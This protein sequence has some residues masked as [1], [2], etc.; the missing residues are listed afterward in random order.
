VLTDCFTF[1]WPTT[2]DDIAFDDVTIRYAPHLE[3]SLRGITLRIPAGSTVAVTGRTGSGKSTL[4]LAL[5]GTVLADPSGAGSGIWIGNMDVAS[6]N[7]H[8]LRRRISFVAQD[9]VL[10]PGSLRENL[11]PIGE[12]T[13]EECAGVLERVMRGAGE[14]SIDSRVDGGGKNLSQGQRQLVGLGRAV[15]RRSPIV[16]LDEVCF[17]PE[18][19]I[20]IKGTGWCDCPAADHRLRHRLPRRSISKHPTTYRKSCGR[21]CDTV[22]SLLL[23]T[24]SR[25]SRTRTTLSC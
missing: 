13:D 22:P 8:A 15:L 4:A 5:L 18:K 9:P 21:N 19:E 7:K 24:E 23:P 17:R 11:D 6:V 1:Q 2:S 14:F 20:L 3:P 12:H 16:I 10:F 25:L